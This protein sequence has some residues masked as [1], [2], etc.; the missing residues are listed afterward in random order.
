MGVHFTQ[1][2]FGKVELLKCWGLRLSLFN[3]DAEALLCASQLVQALGKWQ[4]A[5]YMV[6]ANKQC[7]VC[8]PRGQ[9]RT[10]YAAYGWRVSI[11][12]DAYAHTPALVDCVN[13]YT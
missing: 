2:W 6:H 1:A 11:A 9:I 4:C 10:G 7:P 5:I 3:H 13:R 12:F 8:G